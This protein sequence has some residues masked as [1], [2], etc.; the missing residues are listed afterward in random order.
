MMLLVF[1][2]FFFIQYMELQCFIIQVK[3]IGITMLKDTKIKE[4]MPQN[5]N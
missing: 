1:N 3:I 2:N 5:A 4:L